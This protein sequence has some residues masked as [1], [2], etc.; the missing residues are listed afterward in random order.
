M[1]II[2]SGWGF[3]NTDELFSK[4]KSSEIHLRIKST[5]F[6]VWVRYFV[7]NFNGT[8]WNSTQ[9]IVAIHWKIWFFLYNIEILRA[10][11][12]KNSYAFFK[13]PPDPFSTIAKGVIMICHD[14]VIKWKHFPRYWPFV[15]GIHR[16][17]VNSPHKGQWRGALIFPL[18]CAWIN[19]WV[20]N[21]KAGDLRRHHTQYDVIVMQET[22]NPYWGRTHICFSQPCHHWFLDSN[23]RVGVWSLPWRWHI[24]SIPLTTGRGTSAETCGLDDV[25][26]PDDLG[27]RPEALC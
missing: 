16:S 19:G 21:R 26:P 24:L 13:R 23:R 6:N 7:W 20:N 12:F 15:R 2:K 27:S 10:L 9:D 3:K 1:E 17:P 22:S 11:R 8:L 25:F 4:F 18:I 14:N 5:S